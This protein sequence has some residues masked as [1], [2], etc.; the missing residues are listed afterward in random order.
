[1]SQSLSE[2][3]RIFRRIRIAAR[4]A[5][6][7]AELQPAIRQIRSDLA[8]IANS[9]VRA[10]ALGMFGETVRALRR[11]PK[12]TPNQLSE[13]FHRGVTELIDYLTHS[14]E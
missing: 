9:R 14:D 1:M 7:L 3:I 13:P 12:D 8:K 11:I 2:L 6:S 10:Q 4:G 5:N